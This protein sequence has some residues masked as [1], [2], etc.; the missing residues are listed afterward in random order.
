VR[1]LALRL[2]NLLRRDAKQLST[3]LK[4]GS[5]HLDTTKYRVQFN[6]HI[7][8]L[9]PRE[10]SVLEFLMRHPNEV[11]NADALLNRVWGADSEASPDS[12]K[13]CIS[14]LKSK[15]HG[16]GDLPF[17]ENLFGV[18]YRLTTEHA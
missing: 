4:I 3:E 2:D 8:S 17:V 16:R 10:F 1:E 18:G 15:L 6:G 12:V 13:V 14:R 9:T 7:L 5:L 11:F